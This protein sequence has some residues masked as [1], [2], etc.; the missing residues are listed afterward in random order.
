M[1]IFNGFQNYN[2]IQANKYLLMSTMEDQESLKNNI[3]LNLV[4][5]YL[6]ILLDEELI[7]VAK[8]QY[9][10]TL[11]QVEKNQKLV[12]VGNVARGDLLEIQ[13]QAASEK[14]NLVSR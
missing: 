1:T 5:Y 11:L 6:Q 7:G 9:N 12:E 3:T 14:L 4:G 10:V 8:Q 13:A 2:N